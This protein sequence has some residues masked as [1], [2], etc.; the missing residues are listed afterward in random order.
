MPPLDI[1]SRKYARRELSLIGQRGALMREYMGY[2]NQ[3]EAGKLTPSEGEATTAL[4]RRL[5]AAAQLLRKSLVV[6]RQG[7]AIFSWVEGDGSAP[8]QRGRTWK[9]GAGAD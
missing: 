3:L 4:R 5:G 1:M 6:N 2:I 9:T 7:D 8:R